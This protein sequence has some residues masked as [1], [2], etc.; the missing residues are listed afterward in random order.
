M[1]TSA[2]LLTI[3][4]EIIAS[5]GEARDSGP[6]SNEQKSGTQALALYQDIQVSTDNDNVLRV[7]ELLT[8][9]TNA[10]GI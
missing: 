3:S 6:D 5:N 2:E 1:L 9:A 4:Y 10:Y 7:Q 8:K